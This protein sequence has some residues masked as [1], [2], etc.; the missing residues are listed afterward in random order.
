MVLRVL[1]ILVQQLNVVAVMFLHLQSRK[2]VVFSTDSGLTLFSAWQHYLNPLRHLIGISFTTELVIG[3]CSTRQP[4][5][6]ASSL[7]GQ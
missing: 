1:R 4:T 6:Y 5:S 2:E 3:F 7:Q